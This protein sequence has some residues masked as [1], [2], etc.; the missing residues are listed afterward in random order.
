[1]RIPGSGLV[2]AGA[3]V[4]A[5]SMA[6][7]A[8]GGAEK[9]A[10]TAPKAP[11]TVSS[12]ERDILGTVDAL[13]AATRGSDA[14]SICADIFTAGLVDSIE[15]TAKRSCAKELKRTL[16]APDAEISI[17]RDVRVTGARAT[18]TIRERNNTV[19]KLYL[20]KQDGHWRI[21]R[22]VPARAA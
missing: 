20:L 21:N 16:V 14:R 22:V 8:C 17:G 18:A 15:K 3:T 9:A 2:A 7:S 4:V 19:S 10:S 5:V 6:L 11:A 12:D 1:M 13:N